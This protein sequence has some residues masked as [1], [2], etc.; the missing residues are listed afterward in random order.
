MVA[1]APDTFEGTVN[2]TSGE[3]YGHYHFIVVVKFNTKVVR[4]LWQGGLECRDRCHL[5]TL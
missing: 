4:R 1:L 2:Q 5:L 3:W